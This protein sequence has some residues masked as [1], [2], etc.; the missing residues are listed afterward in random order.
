MLAVVV[1]LLV[2]FVLVVIVELLPCT[3]R[4][5]AQTAAAELEEP[6]VSRPAP[7]LAGVATYWE[8]VGPGWWL[9]WNYDRK[10]LGLVAWQDTHVLWRVFT[11]CLLP[12]TEGYELVELE[13][14]L[15]M[16]IRAFAPNE[17]TPTIEGR[18]GSVKE[19]KRQ[20]NMTIAYIRKEI[21]HF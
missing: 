5:V 7:P 4:P 18:T 14:L 8:Q 21:N 19:A 13:D 2:F 3:R 9:L 20:V 6:N 10:N 17:L 1:A 15:L 11:T 16:G 12:S